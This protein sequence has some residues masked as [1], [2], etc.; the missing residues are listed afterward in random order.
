M[1]GDVAGG[2]SALE[3]SKKKPPPRRGQSK[4]V[5]C[6]VLQGRAVE[7]VIAPAGHRPGRPPHTMRHGIAATARLNTVA[8]TFYKAVPAAS[9]EGSAPTVTSRSPAH[10]S[11]DSTF[12]I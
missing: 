8:G 12:P 9:R 1:G 7:N 6:P 3:L 4:S 2:K 11:S 10:R 5:E